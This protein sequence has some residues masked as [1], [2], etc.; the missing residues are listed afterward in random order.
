MIFLARYYHRADA[1]DC[2]KYI[3]GTK[4]DE[5]IIRCDLDPGFKEGRQFGRGRSGGQVRDEYR[6]EFDA[7]RGG[8]GHRMRLTLEREREQKLKATYEPIKDIPQ[9]ADEYKSRQQDIG[10]YNLPFVTSFQWLMI[11]EMNSITQT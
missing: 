4:L 6:T 11:D 10:K 8:W 3:N 5:R 2:M 1:L 9:G 7:G